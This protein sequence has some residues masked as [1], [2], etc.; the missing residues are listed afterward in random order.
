M[1]WNRK[2]NY[3]LASVLSI[4]VIGAVPGVASANSNATNTAAQEEAPSDDT[5]F[6]QNRAN[7]QIDIK[8]GRAMKTDDVEHYAEELGIETEN[9]NIYEISQEVKEVA[10]KQRASELGITTEGKNLR[11]LTEE[12]REAVVEE[13]ASELGIEIEN[14]DTNELVKAISE[15]ELKAEAVDLGIDPDGKDIAQLMMEVKEEQTLLTAEQLGIETAGKST[16][17]IT[18]EIVNEHAE[19]VKDMDF[20]PSPNHDVDPYMHG[21]RE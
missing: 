7:Q 4:G 10:T 15:A 14:K 19:E 3:L 8:N 11:T 12:V 1:L 17:E 9:K 21:Y 2:G 13:R 18:N 20:F 5:T 16:R 6:S